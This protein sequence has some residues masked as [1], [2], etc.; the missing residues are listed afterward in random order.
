M[1][2]LRSRWNWRQIAW[3]VFAIAVWVVSGLYAASLWI[4]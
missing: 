2:R 3:D 1:P 4:M